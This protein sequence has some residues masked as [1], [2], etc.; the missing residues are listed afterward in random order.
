MLQACFA[1]FP[2]RITTPRPEGWAGRHSL[3]VPQA[4]LAL[5]ALCCHV[6]GNIPS[7]QRPSPHALSGGCNALSWCWVQGIAS[8]SPN[9]PYGGCKWTNG[10]TAAQVEL[11]NPLSPT[12]C[13][14]PAPAAPQSVLKADELDVEVLRRLTANG[15][16][17]QGAMELGVI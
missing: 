13:S 7:T 2:H 15:G 5:P 14:S 1:Y 3:A 16:Q 4:P 6:V 12:P 11:A 8:R 17:G 10:H 9:Y